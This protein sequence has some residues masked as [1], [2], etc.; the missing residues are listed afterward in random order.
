MATAKLHEQEQQAWAAG[1]ADW[2]EERKLLSGPHRKGVKLPAKLDLAGA[3]KLL[4]RGGTLF[5]SRTE[6]RVRGF[7][8]KAGV[9]CSTSAYFAVLSP[10]R[11]LAWC[12]QWCWQQHCECTG[13]PC[14]V[15]KLLE[16]EF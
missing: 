4:P 1:L 10:E 14:H 7:Y 9:K 11:A 16:M 6:G 2:Q 12:L 5:E 3:R 15:D 13:E 8:T